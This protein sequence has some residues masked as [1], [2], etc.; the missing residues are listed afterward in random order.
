MS[1]EGE[2]ADSLSLLS[3]WA[4]LGT[5]ASRCGVPMLGKRRCTGHMLTRLASN[6]IRLC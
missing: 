2:A 1:L 6:L 4:Y 5:R 3:E